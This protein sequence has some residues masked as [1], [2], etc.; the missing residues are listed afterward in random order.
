MNEFEEDIQQCIQ[1]F[2]QHGVI[3]Y[4][5][6]TIW[7]LGCHALDEVAIEKIKNIKN[8]PAEKSFILLMTDVK[9]LRYYTATTPPDLETLIEELTEPTTIIYPNAINLPDSVIADDGSIAVRIT[10]DE[11]CRAL[12]KRMRAPLVST[13]ANISGEAAAPFF[14]QINEKIKKQVDYS[15]TWRK[16]NEEAKKPSTIL[17]MNEDG[18][19]IKLR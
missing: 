13:S 18:T 10:T 12:I 15:V 17:K 3:L 8:R 16:N 7:G 2:D 11:F 19:F 5:T 14:N 1:S 4:P 6:D 9:M